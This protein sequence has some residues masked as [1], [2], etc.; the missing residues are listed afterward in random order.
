MS[1]ANI[2]KKISNVMKY[3]QEDIVDQTINELV[4]RSP[5]HTGKFVQSYIAEKS[6]RSYPRDPEPTG[7][8]FGLSPHADESMVKN[9]AKSALKE[10][11]KL[12]M[13]NNGK[14]SI[15]NKAGH[16]N[17]VEYLGW[18]PFGGKKGPYFPFAT[19]NQS[20]WLKKASILLAAKH[21]ALK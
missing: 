5:V 20:I 16:A 19:T 4:D 2:R 3:M 7:D 1:I 17:F 12:I 15:N 13:E 18:V 21:R 14:V 11:A 10:R 8:I 9:S 6:P